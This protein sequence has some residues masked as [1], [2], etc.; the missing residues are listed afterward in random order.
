MSETDSGALGRVYNDGEVIIRQGEAGECMYV[1]QEGEVEVY[2]EQDGEEVSLAIRK[3]G[4]L[5]GE[6]A[7]F[8]REVRSASV[9]ARGEARVLTLDK[10]NFLRRINEDPS[11]AFRIVQAMSGRIREL[12]KEVARLR[13]H[14]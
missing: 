13:T 1:V 2:T 5:I 10:K 8:E 14:K 12:S 7:I 4:E 9:R 6:M 3:A 11:L